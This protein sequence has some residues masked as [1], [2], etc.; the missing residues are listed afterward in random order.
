MSCRLSKNKKKYHDSRA[1]NTFNSR[2][3][4][5][6]KEGMPYLPVPSALQ[7]QQTLKWRLEK[8]CTCRRCQVL[9]ANSNYGP[10]QVIDSSVVDSAIVAEQMMKLRRQDELTRTARMK[11]KAQIQLNRNRK[12]ARTNKSEISK[13][14]NSNASK[15]WNFGGPTCICQHCHALMWHGERIQSYGIRKP[16]FGICCKRGEVT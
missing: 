14:N 4:L 12:R 2:G 16:T 8:L 9:R 5:K 1:N 6:S 11:R 7:N 15:I 10:A 3:E 13:D